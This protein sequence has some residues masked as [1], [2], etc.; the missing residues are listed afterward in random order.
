[1]RTV[2][3]LS[4][5]ALSAVS[6]AIMAQED[7]KN[8]SVDL[9]FTSDYRFRGISQTQNDPAL[10]V[11]AGYAFDNGFY[12]G[13]WA[14]NVDFVDGDGANFELDAFA[15][16]TLT[17]ADDWALDGQ[18]IRYLYPGNDSTPRYH[19]TEVIGALSWKDMISATVGYSNDV[20]NSSE[21]GI[22]YAL[23]GSYP[24]YEDIS[25]SAAIGNYDLKD[26]A[27]GSYT[28]YELGVAKD[29]GPLSTSLTY[30]YNNGNLESFWGENNDSRFV[31][32][33]GTSF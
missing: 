12:I 3:T 4:L 23:S 25:M 5:L 17:F 15:G 8:W 1:M 14:S 24:V 22:Y 29:F 6:P 13:T 2:L 19:Y 27:G 26:V 33:I 21:T 18:V 9:T 10:Q 31:F 30:H 28:H 16:Y 20:F 7:D 32:A 11:G